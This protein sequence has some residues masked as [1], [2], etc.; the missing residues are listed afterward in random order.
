MLPKFFSITLHASFPLPVPGAGCVVSVGGRLWITPTL[1]FPVLLRHSQVSFE[2]ES[3]NSPSVGHWKP[4]MPSKGD[5]EEPGSGSQDG[6]VHEPQSTEQLNVSRLRSSS[7][8]IREKGSEFL[9]DELHKAQK[10]SPGTPGESGT[11]WSRGGFPGGGD[12]NLGSGIRC[13]DGEEGL[14]LTSSGRAFL[15]LSISSTGAEAQGQRM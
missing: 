10:V 13:W 7:V 11:P 8:E 4:L 3:Q 14:C 1:I 9:R 2:E 5:K 15:S 6:G 12:R